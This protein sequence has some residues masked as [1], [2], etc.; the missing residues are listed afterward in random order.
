MP[1]ASEIS[2]FAISAQAVTPP[3]FSRSGR[4][5]GI[6]LYGG[7][8]EIWNIASATAS[9]GNFKAKKVATLHT[10]R[11]H[12]ADIGFSQDDS[13]AVTACLGGRVRVWDL[14]ATNQVA[15][16]GGQLSSCY[17]VALSPDDSRLAAC[18]GDGTVKLWE[19]VTFKEV[20]NL[21][22]HNYPLYQLAFSSDDNSLVV[23]GDDRVF[24]LRAPKGSER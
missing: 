14:K 6:A 11:W 3:K 2:S 12:F 17:S 16:L 19:T 23:A 21:K 8:A 7:A 9:A 18:G 4:L 1:V 24:I 22:I 5:L 13:T 10:N 20:A 15:D